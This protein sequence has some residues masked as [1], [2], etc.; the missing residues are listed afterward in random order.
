[1]SNKFTIII[2]THGN[3]GKELI[4]SAEMIVGEMKDV[5]FC[6]LEPAMSLKDYIESVEN[7]LDKHDANIIAMTDS[8][9]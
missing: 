5:V 6:P 9:S 4:K 8:Q 7:E 2:G 3:F 1:M